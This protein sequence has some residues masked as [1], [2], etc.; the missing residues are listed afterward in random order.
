MKPIFGILGLLLVLAVVGLQMKSQT[1]AIAPAAQSGNNLETQ[2]KQQLD[3]AMQTTRPNLD[4][5]AG[6]EGK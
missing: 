1:Q 4:D 2:V 3:A 6:A 5:K